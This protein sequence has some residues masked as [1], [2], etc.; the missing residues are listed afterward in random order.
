MAK[1]DSKGIESCVARRN[2]AGQWPIYI[3]FKFYK[4]IK[5]TIKCVINV[6]EEGEIGCREE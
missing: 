3:L 6:A 5:K 1:T 2:Q 4:K